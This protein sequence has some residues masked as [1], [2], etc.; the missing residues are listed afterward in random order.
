MIQYATIT[1]KKGNKVFMH[2]PNKVAGAGVIGKLTGS[3]TIGRL[4]SENV[5]EIEIT[6]KVK[7]AKFD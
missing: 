3:R 4:A 5:Y 2:L 6:D 7:E 1:C